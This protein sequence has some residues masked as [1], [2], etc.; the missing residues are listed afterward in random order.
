[1]P[2]LT[3]VIVARAE[4]TGSRRVPADVRDHMQFH[5]VS[6]WTNA[7]G[8]LE[9]GHARDGRVIGVPTAVTPE[10]AGRA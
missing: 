3:E 10:A 8:A 5:I 1:M 2:R 4:R 7:R 9:P 6:P